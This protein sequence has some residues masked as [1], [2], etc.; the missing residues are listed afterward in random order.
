MNSKHRFFRQTGQRQYRKLFVIATE[1]SVTEP[2]Y[3]NMFN[4][5]TTTIQIKCLKDKNKSSPDQV[6][7]RMEKYLQENDLKKTDQ[8]WLVVDK[9]QWNDNQLEQLYQWSKKEDNYGLAV[10]N[11]KLKYWLLL[12]FEDAK[13]VNNATQCDEKLKK[14]L[15]NYK[16][17]IE[18]QKL[19]PYIQTAINHAKQKDNPPCQKWHKTIGT[20]VYRLVEQL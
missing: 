14:Y 7:K 2:Q 19:I 13:G 16:K 20:T 11:P 4:N 8:A 10:S 1:G 9:D 18:P 5:N 12:H 17:N 3:F 15:P 6:L